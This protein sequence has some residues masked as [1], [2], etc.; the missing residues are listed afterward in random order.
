MIVN[1]VTVAGSLTPATLPSFS[2]GGHFNGTDYA[3]ITE[4]D[5]LKP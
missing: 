1:A 2:Y 4:A 5:L 3:F